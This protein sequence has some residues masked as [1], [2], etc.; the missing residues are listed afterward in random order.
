MA[1]K[2]FAIF[3]AGFWAR[4]QLAARHGLPVICQKPLA[5]SLVE[6]EQM[7]AVCTAAGVRLFIH[8]NWR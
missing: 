7:S 1:N 3:G 4:F 2:Q 6:A 8:E 5:P